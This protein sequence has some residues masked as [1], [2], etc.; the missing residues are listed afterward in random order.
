MPGA[1]PNNTP[2]VAQ[3]YQQHP[4]LSPKGAAANRFDAD[5]Y[6]SLPEGAARV[7]YLEDNATPGIGAL[8]VKTCPNCGADAVFSRQTEQAKARGAA[9]P[10]PECFTCGWP[11]LQSGSMGVQVVA[12]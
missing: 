10:C 3:P 6:A 8:D 11:N 1:W 5:Y 9:P 12:Q 2:Q 7:K 4:D